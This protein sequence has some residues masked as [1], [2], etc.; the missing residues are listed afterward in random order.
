[1]TDTQA[2]T[3]AT[4]QPATGGPHGWR[5][6]ATE[7]AEQV[8]AQ[9]STVLRRRTR[10]LLAQM[11]RPYRR[12]LAGIAT[13]I[14]VTELAVLAGPYLI[15]LGIDR[16]IPPL[17]AR[18]GAHRDATPLLVI[19]GC[20]ALVVAV[21]ALTTRGYLIVTG[22]VGQGMLLTLRRRVFDHFQALSLA[23]HADYT[24]GRVISRQTSDMEAINELVEEG[25]DELVASVLSM[26]LV[27][28]GMLLLDWKLALVVMAAFVP[29]TVLTLWFGRHSTR[30]YRRTRET[31]ALVIVQF[32]ETVRGMRAVHAFRRQRR[33]EQIFGELSAEYRS[34]GLASARLV[35]VYSPA[36]K[37]VGNLTIAAVLAYGGLRV[38]RG[39]MQLGV[40]TAFLLYVR[41]FFDPLQEMAQFYNAFQAAAAALEKLSGVLDERP[42]VPEPAHATPLPDR[43][44]GRLHLDGV[45]FGYRD[46]PVLHGLDLLVPAGQTVALVGET[47]AGKTTIARMIS[48][49][50]DPDGGT[51]SLDGV[52][53]RDITDSDL[54]RSVVLITQENYL[55]SG[56]VADNIALGDPA[57]DRDRITAAAAAI[58]ADTF[59]QALPDGYDTQVNA[60]GV[61]L[62]GGQRQ[63]VAFARA[64]LA[65][66]AVL[67]LDEATSSL[68]VPSERAVQRALR[69]ILADR[70]AVIIAHRLSTVQIA[71]RVLVIDAGRVVEDGPPAELAAGD[72]AYAALHQGWRDSLLA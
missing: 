56:T 61:R 27:G 9:L 70:T 68:D 31:V 25:A 12:Q 47:G 64:F 42:S 45:V 46:V 59:I 19:A 7:H 1:M 8:T 57:A 23:F 65:D 62:S 36:M 17:L 15:A 16:G 33:G 41:R 39:S 40:L 72:G 38:A 66:P 44:A 50:Y 32:V 26:L 35:A 48:R 67:L 54:R 37:L 3:A 55:F 34:A 30:A 5:G 2:D 53:L 69:T 10:V 63:L 60:R 22:R 20:Y 49:G 43:P 24:S 14:A 28:A 11:L 51:V 18:S 6:V 29:L 13:L 58:G 21:Q 4:P 71:D 52:D